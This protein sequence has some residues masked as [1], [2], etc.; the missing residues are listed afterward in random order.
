MKKKIKIII[1]GDYFWSYLFFEKIISNH[2]FDIKLFVTSKKKEKTFISSNK[3]KILKKTNLYESNNLINISKKLDN[4]KYDFIISVAYSKIFKGNFLK[5]N[6]MKILNIHPSFLPKRRGPDPIRNGIINND[7]YF[8]V[9]LHIVE[10]GIDSG[11]L[12]SRYKLKNNKIDH[13]KFILNKL[14]NKFF[15]LIFLDIINYKDNNL[16]CFKQNN[17]ISFAPKIS[18]NQLLI[19]KTDSLNLTKRKIRATLPYKNINLDYLGQKLTVKEISFNYK[20]N[21]TR[22]ALKKG[23][24]Y[25]KK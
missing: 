16:K 18:D 6:S 22:F 23:S 9:S 3:I 21:Y 19:K 13:T 4:I 17:L 11:M 1:F 24:I 8:G 7:K 12:I 15:K 5:K 2:N 14:A 20:K 25:Y 10:R